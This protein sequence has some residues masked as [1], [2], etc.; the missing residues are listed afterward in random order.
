MC[1]DTNINTKK[2][3]ASN[4]IPSTVSK[5][6]SDIFSL[7]LQQI[8]NDDIALVLQQDDKHKTTDLLV[9]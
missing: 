8:W 9:T 7:V 2:V 5:E 6:T 3:V 4:S 1:A